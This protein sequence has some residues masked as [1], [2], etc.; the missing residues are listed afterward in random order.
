[1]RPATL[2]TNSSRP[3]PRARIPG[4]TACATLYRFKTGVDTVTCGLA[5]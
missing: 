5:G 4:R 1:M 3:R 2:D